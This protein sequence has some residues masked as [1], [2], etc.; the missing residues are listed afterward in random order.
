MLFKGCFS[1]PRP[2]H[3][4]RLGEE[5]RSFMHPEFSR[6]Y[7]LK[8]GLGPNQESIQL[9]FW[10]KNNQE[11]SCR[12]AM[13]RTSYAP[14]D[15]A[16]PIWFNTF[17]KLM[18]RAIKS[19][20]RPQ[21]AINAPMWTVDHHCDALISKW[22]KNNKVM[23]LTQTKS[24]C[25]TYDVNPSRTIWSKREWRNYTNHVDRME[26]VET[27]QKSKSMEDGF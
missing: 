7:W 4:P 16:W 23:V 12:L 14:P 9:L 13:A 11:S 15:A 20:A 24:G 21:R 27:R 19:T 25:N 3:R 18:S 22:S 8:R 26:K 10:C 17:T 1:R 6:V 5:R 2:F